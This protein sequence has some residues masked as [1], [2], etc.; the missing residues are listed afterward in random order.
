MSAVADEQLI[1][2]MSL[3]LSTEQAMSIVVNGFIE[4]VTRT[5]PM[6][7]AVESSRRIGLQ[8]EGS[9]G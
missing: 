1:Q 9:V 2:P 3:G 8:M 5:L 6:E 7:H 4:P